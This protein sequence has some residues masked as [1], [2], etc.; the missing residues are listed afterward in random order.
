MKGL[1]KPATDEQVANRPKPLE[2]M[3]SVSYDPETGYLIL[4]FRPRPIQFININVV[5]STGDLENK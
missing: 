1:F 2:D 5:L 4:Y 3:W